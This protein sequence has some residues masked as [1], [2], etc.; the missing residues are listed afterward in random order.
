MRST[1]S[2]WNCRM[3]TWCATGGRW[4]RQSVYGFWTHDNHRIFAT[5][6]GTVITSEIDG[7]VLKAPGQ[8]DSLI[9]LDGP[10][11]TPI[12]DIAIAPDDT[13]QHVV[14][15]CDQPNGNVFLYVDGTNAAQGTIGGLSMPTTATSV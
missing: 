7:L 14:G 4:Q 11:G 5:T 9:K 15:V 10:P 6:S 12:S 3:R 2:F 1:G 8:A 13:W